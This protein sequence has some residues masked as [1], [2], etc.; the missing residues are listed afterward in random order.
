M[1]RYE[2]QEGI[3]PYIA[4]NSPYLLKD[5]KIKSVI[6]VKAID[7]AGNER[8]AELAPISPQY[9]Y[10]TVWFWLVIILAIIILIFIKAIKAIFKKKNV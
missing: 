7:K 5:Q 9:F 2:I 4:G 8:L 1:D 3:E 10:Q 6:R